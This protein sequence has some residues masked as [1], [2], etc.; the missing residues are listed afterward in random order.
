MHMLKYMCRGHTVQQPALAYVLLILHL[1]EPLAGNAWQ[2]QLLQLD[3]DEQ[4]HS[5]S[6]RQTGHS[7]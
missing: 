5:L 7:S 4:E 2:M 1:R 3:D 6:A